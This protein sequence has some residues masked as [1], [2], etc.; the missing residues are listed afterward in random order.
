MSSRDQATFFDQDEHYLV[1]KPDARLAR[2]QAFLRKAVEQYLPSRGRVLDVGCGNGVALQALE[3]WTHKAGV[4]VS[5]QLLKLARQKGIDAH[6]C[7][8]DTGAMPFAD[9]SFDLVVSTDVIE[10]VLHTDHLLNEINRVLRPDGLYVAVI[11]NVN[12]PISFIMQFILDLTPMY[13]ARD[14]CPH[15]RDFSARLFGKILRKHG[16]DVLRREGSFIFPFEGHPVSVAIAK[17]IPRWGAQVLFACRRR[18]RVALQDGFNPNMPDLLQ[19]LRKD[20]P[21]IDAD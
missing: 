7:D 19:W 18:E 16:F 9:A 3:G 21:R 8:V 11:P 17:L 4:D 1:D 10:H 13:A 20:E 5:E 15:Y 12:Q 2:I 6:T 14:R